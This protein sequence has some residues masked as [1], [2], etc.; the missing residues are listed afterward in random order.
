M[1]IF[2][3]IIRTTSAITKTCDQD[4]ALISEALYGEQVI[5][6]DQSKQF[7]LI[8]LLTDS[9]IGWV[10]KDTLGDLP[11]SNHRVLIPRIFV[12]MLPSIKSK[13]INF[14][15]IGSKIFAI[16][17]S[18]KWFQ[19]KIFNNNKVIKAYILIDD[20]V[21]L[22]HRVEDWVSTAQSL[23]NT[24][25]R[26]GGRNTLGMDCSALI[27]LSLQTIGFTMP[28][29]SNVQ[30][31]ISSNEF[32][33]LASLKRGSIIFWKGH[34][35]VMIDEDNFLHANSFHMNTIIEPIRDIIKRAELIN[36]KIIKVINVKLDLSNYP[37]T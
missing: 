21:N 30:Q 28:R 15:S 12:Y 7:I 4:E 13:V 35:G 10:S 2:K 32:N 9:Y 6:L 23:L 36:S 26:W 17:H 8:K 33:G 25:Y 27:Q 16:K 5:F 3:N 18:E 24:P 31:T 29:D 37:L 22:N 1:S 34:V 20:L 11:V 19:V 14:L